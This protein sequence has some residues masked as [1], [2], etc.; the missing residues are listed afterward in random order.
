MRTLAEIGF[1]LGMI[2]GCDNL[3][4]VFVALALISVCSYDDGHKVTAEI[5]E[6]TTLLH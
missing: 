6:H 2:P 1:Q 4:L 5:S 3:V